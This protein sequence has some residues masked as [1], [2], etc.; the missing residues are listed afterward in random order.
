MVARIDRLREELEGIDTHIE[1]AALKKDGDEFVRLSMRKI[2]IP[3]LIR[4]ERAE[5][6]RERMRQLEEELDALEEELRQVQEAE[7]P[8]VPAGRVGHMNP[9][10][11]K[12]A[13][14][15][16]IASRSS[17]L[18]RELKQARRELAELEAEGARP[19]C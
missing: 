18:S 6:M 8:P 3:V 17:S 19:L 1:D 5:P 16:G 4:E 10:M 12:S 11:A 13:R 9:A 14:I 7:P 15:S 2:A